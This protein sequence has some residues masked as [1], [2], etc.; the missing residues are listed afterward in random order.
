MKLTKV[1]IRNYRRLLYS[2][3]EIDSKTT[4]VVGRNNTAKTSLLVCLKTILD[5]KS[6]A[7]S[8]NDYPLSKREGL[9][10]CIE[11]FMHNKIT[12][13]EM[14]KKIETISVLFVVDY[15]IEDSDDPLGA[16]SPFIID[17]DYDTTQ[18]WI[19]AEQ[20][21]IADENKIKTIFEDCFIDGYLDSGKVQKAFLKYYSKLFE[22]KVYAIN[23]K[24]C[25]DKQVRDLKELRQLFPLQMIP[26]ER[27]LGEDEKHNNSLG[28][29]IANFFDVEEEKLNRKIAD[30]II[31]LRK[32]VQSVNEEIQKN[33]ED[34][35][36]K[37]VNDAIGF[38]YPNDVELQLGVL[39]QIGID[40]QIKNH[41]SLSYRF[42]DDKE[43]L[44]ETYNGLGYKNLI[45]IEF[46][47][48]TFANNIEKHSTASI[49]L[50][51]IEEPESHMH[52]QMQTVFANYLEDF[53]GKISSVDIQV[54]MTSHSSYITNS[55]EF[56]K[57]RYAQKTIEGIKFKNLNTFV[58]KNPENVEFIR[59]YLTLTRCDMFFADKLIFVEGASERILIPDMINKMKD[60]GLFITQKNN[61]SSQYYS[62]IEI[63]GAYAH[64]FIPFVEFLEIPC[65]IITDIDPIRNG[66]SANVDE[67]EFTSNETIKWWVRKKKNYSPQTD[68]EFSEICS[69]SEGEKTYKKCHIEFQ[70]MEKGLCGKSLEEAI[71]NVNRE[72]YNLDEDI[73]EED[74]KFKGKCKTDFALKLV[75]EHHKYSIPQYIISGLKWL[76]DV[77]TLE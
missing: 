74:L 75:Y 9:Y 15:S 20:C 35:L 50:L 61:L 8:F 37:V 77:S 58:Q 17:L 41:T 30:D 62:L 60:D 43:S 23:P 5:E 33:S 18:A 28:D 19:C 32:K 27:T 73:K 24:N 71:I 7:F 22:L 21:F 12:F 11:S 64:K 47:L 56:P 10:S 6:T 31:T 72:I 14:C 26:A 3:I 63:G 54:F 44:P 59:K 2:E 49:P 42:K 69:L 34:T 29:L 46:L 51:F 4:L 45:K 16:L 65:L 68:I 70:T 57:I 40:D 66:I 1:I 67:G 25:E 52:P 38:G 48:A 13:E 76:N 36:S 53:L 39:T 55:V